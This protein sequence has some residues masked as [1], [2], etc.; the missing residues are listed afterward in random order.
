M[1]TSCTFLLS[2]SFID[3][4]VGQITLISGCKISIQRIGQR[5][6][7]ASELSLPETGIR[8]KLAP[9]LVFCVLLPDNIKIT[10]PKFLHRNSFGHL[11][12]SASLSTVLKSAFSNANFNFVTAVWCRNSVFNFA[13]PHRSHKQNFCA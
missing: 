2:G 4:N 8:A 12:R 7:S 11:R 10:W 1:Q 5:R 13:F 9:R 6:I 3:R